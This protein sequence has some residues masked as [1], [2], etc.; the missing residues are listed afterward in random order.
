MSKMKDARLFELIRDFLSGFLPDTKGASENTVRAYREALRQFL[1]WICRTKRIA[2]HD[3]SSDDFTRAGVLDYLDSLESE[4]GCSV[5]TRNHRLCCLRSFAAFASEEEMEYV[6]AMQQVLSVCLK[7]AP[8]E[9]SV[10][11]LSEEAV[12][13]L[14]ALP[15]ASSPKGRRDL[16]LMAFMYDTGARVQEV[17]NM[18]IGDLRLDKSPAAKLTGKG[19]KT[20]LVPLMDNTARLLRAYVSE[21]GEGMDASSS[22]PLFP[23]RVG[24]GSAHMTEDNV[25]KLVRMYGSRIADC[26]GEHGTALHPHMIRHSRAMHL[27]QNGMSLE[28]LS[29]WLGHSHVETTL[30]YAHADTEMKR[31]AIESATPPE[32]KL[33]KHMKRGRMTV[34]NEEKLK[35]LYALK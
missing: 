31:K 30:I 15:D 28:L 17:V 34:D 4:K 6:P 14:L 21:T 7:A 9:Q 23:S 18:A 8:R 27:Y 32:S 5:S 1:D 13:N 24:D 16:A 19:R 35:Q 25:R 29:Q 11:H 22:R 20:R 10:R 33:A 12:A 3:V 26:R 2:L